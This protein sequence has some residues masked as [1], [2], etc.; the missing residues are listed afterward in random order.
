MYCITDG[1]GYFM[2][3]FFYLLLY[4]LGWQVYFYLNNR[5]SIFTMQ[6]MHFLIRMNLKNVTFLDCHKKY[7]SLS[8]DNSLSI[9]NNSYKCNKI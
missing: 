1:Q 3:S 6:S 9:C 2:D 4:R 7:C 5:Y 8:N